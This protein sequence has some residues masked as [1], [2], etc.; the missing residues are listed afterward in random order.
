LKYKTNKIW[1]QNKNFKLQEIE[2]K[3]K[4]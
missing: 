4:K 3:Q 2:L 1:D